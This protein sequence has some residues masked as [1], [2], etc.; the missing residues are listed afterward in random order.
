MNGRKL[1]I[2]KKYILE[3]ILLSII[4]LCG[5]KEK[6]QEVKETPKESTTAEINYIPI[7]ADEMEALLSD[8]SVTLEYG[9]FAYLYEGQ[10]VNIN[11]EYVDFQNNDFV[12][13]TRVVNIDEY[14]VEFGKN[15]KFHGNLRKYSDDEFDTIYMRVWILEEIDEIDISIYNSFTNVTELYSLTNSR[16]ELDEI[17]V[18]DVRKTFDE[19]DNL[20]DAIISFKV[21]EETIGFKLPGTEKFDF[22]IQKGDRIK[23]SFNNFINDSYDSL[24]EKGIDYLL[25]DYYSI[26]YEKIV[27]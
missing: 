22:D 18:D 20:I 16:F 24:K 19:D 12:I 7:N 23:L 1:L 27:A 8:S 14:T 17:L 9:V 25:T 11:G 15:Y 3:L 21:G 6:G 10:V 5:C 4:I 2:M 13:R 26:S